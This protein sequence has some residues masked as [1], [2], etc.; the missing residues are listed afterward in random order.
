MICLKQ[1]LSYCFKKAGKNFKDIKK[2]YQSQVNESVSK[3][4]LY[5]SQR[6]EKNGIRK[7]RT[8]ELRASMKNF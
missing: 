7:K 8:L 1:R 2:V 5:S 3:T 4:V 6:T